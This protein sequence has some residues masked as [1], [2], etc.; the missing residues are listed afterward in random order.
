[1]ASR[2]TDAEPDPDVINFRRVELLRAIMERHGDAAT[3]VYITEGGWNDDPRWTNAVRPGQRIAYTL[4]AFD[5]V[6]AWPWAEKF[7][8]WHFRQPVDR[9]NRRDTYYALV[10]S[11]Y[12]VRPIYEAIQAYARGWENPYQP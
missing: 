4:Q 11:D 1:M 9:N 10:S 12:Y 5:L 7:C 3:P 8:V 2:P 6:E